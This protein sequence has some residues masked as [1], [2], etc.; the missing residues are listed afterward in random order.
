MPRME[1]LARIRR[2]VSDASELQRLSCERV[3][4]E[5]CST[6]CPLNELIY[7]WPDSGRTICEMLRGIREKTYLNS[8]VLT[9]V[10]TK[11]Y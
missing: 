5:K 9:E 2:I 11:R 4:G 10:E 1:E 3:S 8:I 6:K 7:L